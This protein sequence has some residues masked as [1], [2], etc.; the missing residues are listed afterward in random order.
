MMICKTKVTFQWAESFSISDDD[1]DDNDD[2]N[3]DDTD[4]YNDNDEA[5]HLPVGGT[6]STCKEQAAAKP[7]ACNGKQL[8]LR[9]TLKN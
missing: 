6:E 1:N 3:D 8:K 9:T 4:D 5:G 2:D 7:S